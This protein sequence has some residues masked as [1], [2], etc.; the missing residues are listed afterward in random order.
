LPAWL[1][2]IARWNPLSYAVAPLRE[3]VGTGL[4]SASIGNG[5]LAM[6]IFAVLMSLVALRQF[7][8]SIAWSCSVRQTGGGLYPSHIRT[9]KR[10]F[11]VRN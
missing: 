6:F 8:R 1:Q 4:W 10:D 3:L 2:T 5:L 9:K 11:Y 7:R